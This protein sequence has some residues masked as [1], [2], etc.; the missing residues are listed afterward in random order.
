[1]STITIKL[2]KQ[3]H[4]ISKS[5]FILG[6]YDRGFCCAKRKCSENYLFRR[7]AAKNSDEPAN[8][9]PAKRRA[10]FVHT[11]HGIRTKAVLQKRGTK[12]R[13]GQLV[14]FSRPYSQPPSFV[15]T[16]S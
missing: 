8:I 13:R 3:I 7:F 4:N 10:S 2:L 1:M 16:L 11:V 6:V 5:R 14:C 12:N 9:S 15:L